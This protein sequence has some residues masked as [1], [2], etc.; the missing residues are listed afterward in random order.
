MG[1]AERGFPLIGHAAT[2]QFAPG[3]APE[4]ARV[5]SRMLL[6]GVS[7]HGTVRVNGC[8]HVLTAQTI[9]VL[10]WRHSV[11]YRPDAEDPYLVYGA[12]LIPWHAA[13][14]PVEIAVPHHHDHPLAG[15]AWR[16]DTDVGIGPDLWITDA[17]THQ[18]L[19]TLIKLIAQVWDRGTPGVGTAHALGVLAVGELRAGDRLLPQIDRSLPLRLRRVLTWVAAGPGRPIT[20]TELAS[21]ADCSP[22]TLNRL[23]RHYLATSPLAWVLKVRTD[24]AKELLT[25]TTLPMNEI[26]RRVGFRDAYYFSRQ[27]RRHTGQSPTSWRRQWA[28]P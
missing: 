6:A 1:A 21:V 28:G 7:G 8:D 20:V 9:M 14:Q 24:A 22:A 16:G 23:F 2:V 25:T 27:F 17:T 18:T 26:A 5:E 12:H 13:D 11:A 19:K 3:A 10:P 4:F 15:A